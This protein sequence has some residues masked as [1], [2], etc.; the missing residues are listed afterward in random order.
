MN[1]KTLNETARGMVAAGRGI[2]AADESTGTI[3]KRFDNIKVEN[4]EENRR[5]YRDMLFTA[6]GLETVH[7][8]RDSFTKR[9]CSR[10]PATARRSR[11]LLARKG[12][13]P[14]HQGRQ[15]RQAAAPVAPKRPSPKASTA[16]VSA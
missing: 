15:G 11:K 16:C 4:T 2:L 5:S 1:R 6:P 10:R 13:H 14:R 8:R 7:Q 9:P 3:E 12:H